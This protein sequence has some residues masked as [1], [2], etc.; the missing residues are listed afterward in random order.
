VSDVFLGVI[1]VA[2]AIMAIVQLGAIVF[3][4]KAARRVDEA[5]TR[6]ERDVQ[7]I[8][9]NLQSLSANAAQASGIAAAQAERATEMIV[10]LAKRVD[11]TAAVVQSSIVGPAREGY[12]IFQG[13]L[14]ALA[15]L[16]QGPPPRKRPPTTDDEDALFIG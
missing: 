14:A 15:T 11:D 16:R 8:V 10:S 6:L 3:A 9:A 12:A 4:L 5:V 1:A 2:V 13:V 7:P